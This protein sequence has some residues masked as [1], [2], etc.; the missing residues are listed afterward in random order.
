MLELAFPSS[1]FCY[2][3]R[4][5]WNSP[6][7]TLKFI[8]EQTI[9]EIRHFFLLQGKGSSPSRA[10]GRTR[11]SPGARP[12]TRRGPRSRWTKRGGRWPGAGRGTAPAATPRGTRSGHVLGCMAFGVWRFYGVFWQSPN[13]KLFLGKNVL[14][15]KM[16]SLRR[17]NST[18]RVFP[19]SFFSEDMKI[20]CVVLRAW[21]FFSKIKSGD[22]NEST[23]NYAPGKKLATGT[24]R[25]TESLPMRDT[26]RSMWWR[27]CHN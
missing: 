17:I 13:D 15:Y 18:H 12:P 10:K 11:R 9:V 7:L 4:N 16:S 19:C 21:I 26:K 22:K 23:R 14:K 1:K 24:G 5:L 2:K 8:S 20:A 3:N 27:G 6:C 25:L